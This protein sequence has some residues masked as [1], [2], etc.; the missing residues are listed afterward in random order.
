MVTKGNTHLKKPAAK[1]VDFQKKNLSFRKRGGGTENHTFGI[2]HLLRSNIF[3]KTNIS[4]HLIRTRACGYQG[5]RNVS[6]SK[7]V[8]YVLNE[9]S[10]R[11]Q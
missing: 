4:Y 8:A 6:F 10:L 1:S 11:V 9:L 3:R 7:N 5:V 2:I